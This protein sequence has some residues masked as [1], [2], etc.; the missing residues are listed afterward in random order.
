[1]KPLIG[2][3]CRPAVSAETK[4]PIY[5]M[6]R[7][8][9]HAVESSG[10]MPLLIPLMNSLEPLEALLPHLAGILFPGGVDI[11]PHLYNE[12]VRQSLETVDPQL[13][14]LEFTLAHW[15]LDHDIPLLGICRG[16]QL[17]NVA[18]GGS[19]Y[20]DLLT[21]RPGSKKHFYIDLPRS[22]LTN[23]LSIE[24][25]SRMEKILGTRE[26]SV[27]SLHHQG[28]KEPGKGVHITGWAEDGVPELL[29]T[30]GYRFVLGVQGH[31]EELYT[32]HPT[33]ARI[34]RAFV[35]ACMPDG[36]KVEDGRKQSVGAGESVPVG[37]I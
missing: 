33:W 22:E 4:R 20:Q 16:M 13:D 1:M 26:L 14:H 3:P 36:E 18:L 6:N 23:Q 37:R 11:Q 27:N 31:P 24:A 9:V 12:E 17:I 28:V 32:E 5:C 21:E 25:G 8:Y 29:E 35:E 34:F 7:T 15:A 10:G 30:E 2:I 19:L